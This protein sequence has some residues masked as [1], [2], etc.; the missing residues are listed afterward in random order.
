[1][2]L[3][4]PD[5]TATGSFESGASACSKEILNFVNLIRETARSA[6]AIF[7]CEVLIFPS[8]TAFPHAS[9]SYEVK[10]QEQLDREVNA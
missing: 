6:P 1:M 10:E 5:E 9:V 4:D 3:E 8:L 2:Q 7:A